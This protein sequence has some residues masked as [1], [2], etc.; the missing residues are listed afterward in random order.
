MS[1]LSNPLISQLGL[2]D[3]VDLVQR[4]FQPMLAMVPTEA[5]TLFINESIPKNT[6]ASRLYEEIDV[7]TFA[8]LK[9]EGENASKGRVGLGYTKTA[10]MRRYAKEIDITWEMRSNAKDTDV[11]S[12]FTSLAQFIPQRMEIDLTHRFT[13]ASSTT[14]TDMDGLVQDISVG[15][16]LALASAA[17]TLA[18]SS[19]TYSN[20]VPNNPQFSQSSYESA[21]ELAATNIY[22]NFGE[23]RVMDFNTVIFGDNPRY[24]RIVKQL[25]NSMADPDAAQAGVENVYKGAFKYKQL[26]YMASDAYGTYNSAKI[27]YWFLGAITG[28]TNGWQAYLA[29]F[30]EPN[31]KTPA[32]GNNGEDAHN[33]NWTF[34]VRGAWDVAVVSSRGL[35]CSLA[36]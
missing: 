26:R 5:R 6:G 31:M 36:S 18:F 17:H 35:I 30:E 1:Q 22:S 28:N 8:K 27:N 34:G 10:T 14:Y 4:N 21:L 23:K 19:T 7:E 16:T 32:K 29:I 11:I 12:K 13:F 2:T 15:D 25:L 3:L 9:R 33:D 24:V 20:I